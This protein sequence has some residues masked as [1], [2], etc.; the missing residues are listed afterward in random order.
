MFREAGVLHKSGSERRCK[1]ACQEIK[2]IALGFEDHVGVYV[3]NWSVS[4]SEQL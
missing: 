2:E 4:V 1:V 3:A